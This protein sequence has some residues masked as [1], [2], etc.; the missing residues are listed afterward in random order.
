VDSGGSKQ[1]HCQTILQELAAKSIEGRHLMATSICIKCSG[2]S[3]EV[4]LFTPIGDSRKLSIVQCSGCG[5]PVGVMDPAA[6]PQ[7]EALK[8]QVAAIDQRLSRIAQALQD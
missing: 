5:T 7:I 4:V 2:H 3:F 6:G 1:P 8:A